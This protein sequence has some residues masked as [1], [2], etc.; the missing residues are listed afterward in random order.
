MPDEASW[1]KTTRI[2]VHVTGGSPE[3]DAAHPE[4]SI[5]SDAFDIIISSA[6]PYIDEYSQ[7][8][9]SQKSLKK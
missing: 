5:E 8:S 2:E 7:K 6:L 3:F 4:L 1:K 9:I